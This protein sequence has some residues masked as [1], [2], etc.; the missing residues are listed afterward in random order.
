MRLLRA[1][2][3]VVDL[4]SLVNL[5]TGPGPLVE[6]LRALAVALVFLV[7]VVLVSVAVVFGM[8][9]LDQRKPPYSG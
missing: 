8:A 2:L 1:V 7:A 9:L 5:L 3:V 4:V 6:Q